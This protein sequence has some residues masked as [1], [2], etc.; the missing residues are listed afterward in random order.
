MVTHVVVDGIGVCGAEGALDAAPKPALATCAICKAVLLY[1]G[2]PASTLI[3]DQWPLEQCGG[4]ERR[5][6]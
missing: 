4:A 6:E 5:A 3:E 1:V 2:A